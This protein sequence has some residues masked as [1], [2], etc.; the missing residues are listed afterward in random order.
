MKEP[1]VFSRSIE[2]EEAYHAVHR[3]QAAV[4]RLLSLTSLRL[5]G[6]KN[7]CPIEGQKTDRCFAS[8]T[9]RQ[10]PL[11]SGDAFRMGELSGFKSL[12][13]IAC[14]THPHPIHNAHPDVCQSAQGHAVRF[15]FRGAG[16]LLSAGWRDPNGLAPIV[17]GR[18][19]AGALGGGGEKAPV[20]LR[21]ELGERAARTPAHRG[22]E[23]KA[24]LGPGE[25]ALR[26]RVSEELP[27]ERR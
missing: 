21:P 4:L 14:L 9:S 20:L 5:R 10:Q 22:R 1:S 15:A 25:G 3:C 16:L 7:P 13:L 19:A 2:H 27:G 17:L 24:L 8:Q 26:A 12:G 11:N 18:A 23:V 6:L